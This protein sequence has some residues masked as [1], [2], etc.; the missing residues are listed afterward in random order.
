[1]ATA[2][3]AIAKALERRFLRAGQLGVRGRQSCALVRTTD[4]CRESSARL[5]LSLVVVILPTEL[6]PG[7]APLVCDLSL[8][9][10]GL[11]QPETHALAQTGLAPW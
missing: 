10:L 5:V 11:D 9:G 6:P 7:W 4:A 3:H 2:A 1:M 8:H